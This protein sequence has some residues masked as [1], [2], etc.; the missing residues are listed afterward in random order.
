M[1]LIS[2]ILTALAAGAWANSW[3]KREYKVEKTPASYE[4]ATCKPW[5][6]NCINKTSVPYPRQGHVALIYTTYNYDQCS[7]Y[8]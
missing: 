6:E 3:V 8:A 7:L 2:L 5:I 1:K 4:M